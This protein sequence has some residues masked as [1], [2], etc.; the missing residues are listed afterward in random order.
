MWPITLAPLSPSK[1]LLCHH[2]SLLLLLLRQSRVTS[3][4]AHKI[5]NLLHETYTFLIGRRREVIFRF[6]GFYIFDKLTHCLQRFFFFFMV[7]F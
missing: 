7:L 5:Q 4:F 6:V 3:A 1:A 2:D